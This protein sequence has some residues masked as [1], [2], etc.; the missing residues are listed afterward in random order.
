M[1]MLLVTLLLAPSQTLAADPVEPRSPRAPASWEAGDRDQGPGFSYQIFSH[2]DPDEDF[3]RY[4]VR[5]TIEASPQRLRD[6]VRV[7]AADPEHAPSGHTR[8]MIEASPSD[9]V[10]HTY[11]ALP[12]LSDRDI[13]TRGV[14]SVDAASGIHR[15]E[16]RAVHDPRAPESSDAI[17][18]DQAAGFWEFA[19]NG[20]GTTR[21]TYETYLDLG[22]SIPR[23]LV[24]AMMP[25]MVAGNFADVASEARKSA[26]SVGAA[27]PAE[28]P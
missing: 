24:N 17:R 4:Q 26:A 11:I 8:R 16:W 27:P 21:V 1:L 19:P 28:Q 5:G 12:L 3:V 10:V 9:F 14:R 6:S 2:V 7:I 18:I 22:G 23:W 13:V 15:I 25:D 20:D